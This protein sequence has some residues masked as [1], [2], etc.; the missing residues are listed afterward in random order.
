MGK[1][2]IISI[3]N[4]P[5]DGKIMHYLLITSSEHKVILYLFW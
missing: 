3:K 2:E 4:T 5:F 1:E